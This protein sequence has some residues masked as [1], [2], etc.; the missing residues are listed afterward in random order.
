MLDFKSKFLFD[1]AIVMFG[2][3]QRWLTE[4]IKLDEVA[5]NDSSVS[6]PL[7]LCL[8]DSIV[9]AVS[10]RPCLPSPATKLFFM[11]F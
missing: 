2:S 7:S 5:S 10:Y 11:S 1:Y 8:P 4:S 9:F 6:P 3:K